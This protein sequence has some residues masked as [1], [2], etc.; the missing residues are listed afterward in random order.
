MKDR[1][2]TQRHE[3]DKKW[4]EKCAKRRIKWRLSYVK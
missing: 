2:T 3:Q 1:T 4:L